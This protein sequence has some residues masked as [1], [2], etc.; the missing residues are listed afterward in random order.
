MGNRLSAKKIRQQKNSQTL[1]NEFDLV[2]CSHVLEHVA[3]HEEGIYELKR[4]VKPNGLLILAV[5]NEGCF[6]ATLRNKFI[7]RSIHRTTD[8]VHFYTSKKIESLARQVGLKSVTE[9]MHHGNFMPHLRLDLLLREYSVGRKFLD[10][11][12]W[13][14]PSQSGGLVIGLTKTEQSESLF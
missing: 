13:C 5:P 11:V 7:Q 12:R 10:L 4:I 1:D 8:H 9:V 6:I 3:Q 2:L 14:F